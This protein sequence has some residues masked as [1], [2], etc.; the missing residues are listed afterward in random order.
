MNPGR[1]KEGEKK[2]KKV[3]K[4]AERKEWIGREG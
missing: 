2:K 3:T 1:E 4:G